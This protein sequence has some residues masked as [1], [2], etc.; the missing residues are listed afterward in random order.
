MSTQAWQDRGLY[1]FLASW[2]EMRHDD[3]AYTVAGG[4]EQPG[5]QPGTQA[6]YVEPCPEAYARLAAM[7]DMMR[8]GL[9]DRGLADVPSSERLDAFH[10]LLLGLKTMAEK[11]LRG[12]TLSAEE[13]AVIAGIGDTMQYLATFSVGEKE[14]AF[15]MDAV[16]PQTSAAYTDTGFGETLQ[17]AVAKPLIYYV[18]VPVGGKP[19]LTTGAGYSYFEFVKPADSPVTDEAW[20]EMVDSGQ[21]PERPAWSSS[22]L[23]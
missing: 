19:T 13:Y 10:Q 1:A 21:L 11:E 22:F 18:I 3:A 4:A 23:Q 14:G 7:T 5:A 9:Q 6:G 12:E 16:L 15:E 8:R 17:V 20:R 2:A